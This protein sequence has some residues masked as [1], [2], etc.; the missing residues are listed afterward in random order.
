MLVEKKDNTWRLYIDYRALNKIKVRNQYPIP[1]IDDLLDQLKGVKLFIKIDRKYGY[2]QVPIEPI[3]VWKTTFKSKEGIFEWLV[4]PVGLTNAP[5]TFMS[6]MDDVL[7]P[8]TNYF[9]VV[10]LDEILIFNRT[11]DKHMQHIQEVLGTLR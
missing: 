7:I 3:D 10:Y 8:F 5:A 2:H 4:M 9:L 11:L 1:R 6:L